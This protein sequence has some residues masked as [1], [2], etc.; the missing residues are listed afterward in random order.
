MCAR[1]HLPLYTPRLLLRDFILAD[2]QA[3][4]AYASDPEVT[5][6]MFYGPRDEADTAAY[7]QRMLQS[8]RERPRRIWELAVIRREDARLIGA[9]DVTLE[10]GQAGRPGLYLR[11]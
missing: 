6:F 3:I 1:L 2:F 9:C 8:Q 7:L 4:H 5:E 10:D 11:P